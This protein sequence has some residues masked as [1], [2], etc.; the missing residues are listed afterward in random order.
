VL[1]SVDL[2][3]VFL[4]NGAAYLGALVLVTFVA[5]TA[6]SASGREP[7]AELEGR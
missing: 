4:V 5:R 6:R 1:G 2:R 3:V 7:T